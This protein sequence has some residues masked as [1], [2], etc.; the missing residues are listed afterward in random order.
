MRRK[1]REKDKTFALGIIDKV[2]FG[3]MTIVDDGYSIP[4]SFARDGDYLY[5]HGAKIGEK[6]RLLEKE[7][8]VRIVFVGD[9][10]LPDPIRQEEIMK[11]P[12]KLAKLFTLKY[13]SA[14]VEGTCSL[15]EDKKER[16]L[17]LTLICK[18]F[19]PDLDDYIKMA[20]DMNGDIT[21]C[22][23]IKI[24]EISGKSNIN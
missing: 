20:V 1:D 4:L 15:I 6:N 12:K 5:F 18:K 19:Y 14:I 24:E 8:H 10:Y 2:S 7:N 23:K 3:V 13:E 16:D 9:N 17:A 22:Y 11:E 21:A